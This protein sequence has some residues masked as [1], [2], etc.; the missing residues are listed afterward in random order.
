MHRFKRKKQN[1]TKAKEETT[2]NYTVN[3]RR[4]KRRRQKKNTHINIYV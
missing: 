4:G 3:D 1:K 2:K